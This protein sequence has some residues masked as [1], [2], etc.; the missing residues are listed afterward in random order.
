MAKF[1]LPTENEAL[2]NLGISS[3]KTAKF[4]IPIFDGPLINFALTNHE[5]RKIY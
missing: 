3:H 4:R 5:N 2:L 1:M